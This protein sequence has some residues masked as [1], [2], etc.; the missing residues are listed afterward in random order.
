M[1]A[2][3][4]ANKWKVDETQRNRKAVPDGKGCRERDV[5]NEKKNREPLKAY[6]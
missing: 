4:T 2:E 6:I 3:K 1:P 5:E